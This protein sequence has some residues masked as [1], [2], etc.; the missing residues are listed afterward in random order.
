MLDIKLFVLDTNVILH[1]A[2]CIFA[3]EENDIAIPITVLEELDHFK[4]GNEDIHFQA[5]TFLRSLDE[6]GT[7]LMSGDGL[8]LG[9][10]LGRIRVVFEQVTH[11][12]ISHVFLSD[13]ADHRILNN[14]IH[15]AERIQYRQVVLVSKDTNIRLKA[16]SLGLAAEDYE[17]DKLGSVDELYSGKRLIEGVSTEHIGLFFNKVGNVPAADVPLIE[18]PQANENFIYR[19]GSKS[20]LLT[21]RAEERAF[22]RVD[23]KSAYGIQP[24]NAE[25][26]FALHALL[27][28]RLSLVTLA[29]KAGTGKTLLALAAALEQREAFQQILL[30]RP[31]VPLSNRDLG[32][33]PGD[34]ESKLEPYMQPLF[35][36]LAVIRNQF[37]KTESMAT[38]IDRML[39]E[40]RLVVS[41]L[42]Y[43]RGRSIQKTFFIVD[44]A[45]NLTPH[46]VKTIITRA[47][48]GTKIVLTGDIEQIDHP[49]LDKLSN[50]F[51]HLINRM[52]GQRIY[53]HVSLEKGERSELAGLAAQIL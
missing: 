23:K 46:E 27:D 2:R 16:R 7:T 45:Q 40:E 43:I 24:R 33:L 17:A 21:Y 1:D 26:F 20:A 8:S 38:E 50:G 5:R 12:S 29:G 30:A 47:G 44:E 6:L 35:D 25:Q 10:G 48:E 9:D 39:Q 36:N 3:F 22:A 18:Q 53:A 13:Q 28:Q 42:S 52:K 34:I 41:P 19:N 37:R 14:A 31:I 32:F 49:Y 15:L 4:R 11:P 51:A